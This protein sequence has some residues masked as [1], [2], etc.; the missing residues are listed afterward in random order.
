VDFLGVMP[1]WF[2]ND[3]PS[4]RST[5]ASFINH[6]AMGVPLRPSTPIPLLHTEQNRTATR[7]ETRWP[8]LAAMSSV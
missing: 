5:S 1:V 3:A 7:C 8:H 6:E 4:T 2:K